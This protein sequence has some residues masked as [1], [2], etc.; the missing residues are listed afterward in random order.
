M[1]GKSLRKITQQLLLM[2]YMSRKQIYTSC[3]R[4]KTQLK[5]QKQIIL[6]MFPNREGWHYTESAK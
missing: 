4:F 1:T 3:L 5:S 6:L 2:R